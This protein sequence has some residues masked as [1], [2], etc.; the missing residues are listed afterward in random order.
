M[1]TERVEGEE[2]LGRK[3]L[4]RGRALGPSWK[5][6][7]Q[8]RTATRK[9]SEG[10][11]VRPF[12]VMPAVKARRRGPGRLGAVLSERHPW[13]AIKGVAREIERRKMQRSRSGLIR[14][15]QHHSLKTATMTTNQR[16]RAA[17]L[18][19]TRWKRPSGEIFARSGA[20]RAPI[21]FPSPAGHFRTTRRELRGRRRATKPL[22]AA[23]TWT[24]QSEYCPES[25]RAMSQRLR[26]PRPRLV[27]RSCLLHAGARW[28]TLHALRPV[29]LKRRRCR[30]RP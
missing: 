25:P 23:G 12:E 16:M 9:V 7:G 2:G 13:A 14:R 8:Q 4:A 1:C 6:S 18:H 17:V 20:S 15:Q 28:R 22:D 10:V 24:L 3:R 19:G 29:V 30:L 21:E 5:A 27:P 11:C 26:L